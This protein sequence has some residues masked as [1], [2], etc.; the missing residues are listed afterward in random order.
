MMQENASLFEVYAGNCE[1]AEAQIGSLATDIDD[2]L[3]RLDPIGY[4]K[5]CYRPGVVLYDLR[6]ESRKKILNQLRE[7]DLAV[8]RGLYHVREV[9][10]D[11]PDRTRDEKQLNCLIDRVLKFYQ[12]PR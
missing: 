12:R 5:A 8:Q 10:H 3:F 11:N 4:L 7:R 9:L 6:Q 2:I 1:V